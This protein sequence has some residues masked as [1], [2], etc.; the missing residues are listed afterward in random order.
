MSFSFAGYQLTP[1][2]HDERF[3]EE[4][5]FLWGR[6][7]QVEYVAGIVDKDATDNG[8]TPTTQLRKGLAMGVQ[9]ATKQWMQWN[10][11]ATDGTQYL[12]GF[13]IDEIDTSYIGGTTKERLNAIVVKGNIKADQIVIAGEANRG[14]SGKAYEFLL[15]QQAGDRFLF[16]DDLGKLVTWKE[17][18]MTAAEITAHAVTLTT[19][20]NRTVLSNRGESANTTVMLPAPVPGLEFAFNVVAAFNITVD[21]PATGEFIT[22]ATATTADTIVLTAAS[23]FEKNVTIKAIRTGASTYKYVKLNN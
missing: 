6:W 22:P 14:L 10:P 3:T 2:M 18:E 11:Y 5:N 8:N 9:T 12:M 19:A 17:R 1:G 4:C 20:D 23:T 21:G 13:L 15:R 16:D 7:D